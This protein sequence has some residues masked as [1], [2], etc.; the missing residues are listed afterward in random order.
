MT[1]MQA[2][3][4]LWRGCRQTWVWLFLLVSPFCLGQTLDLGDWLRPHAEIL[5][6]WQ[7]NPEPST[8]LRASITAIKAPGSKPAKRVLVLYPRASSA[9]D[10]ALNRLLDVF[11]ERE[12]N[13]T[14]TVIN[15][16]NNPLL[17]IQALEFAKAANMDLIYT[18]GSESTDFVFARYKDGKIPTVSICSKDPVLLGQM[19]D[20]EKGSE[21]H[22]AFTSLNMQI[23]AQLAYLQELKPKLRN[24]GILVDAKNKSAVQ[25]Q[26]DPIAKAAKAI[27]IEPISIVVKEPEMAVQEL[28]Q[29]I[30]LALEAMR[31]TDPTLTN[32]V[33]WLTGSTSVFKE[34]ATINSVSANVPVISVVP[35]VA[36]EGNDSAVLSIGISFDSNAYLAAI[37]GVDILTGKSRPGELKVGIVSPPDIAI[38]FRRARQIGLKIPFSFFERAGYIYDYDGKPARLKGISQVVTK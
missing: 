28:L 24:I 3:V 22:F 8:P 18:M 34:I 17:G 9:Y 15:F 12:M 2:R 27:G 20:Y 35:E 36:T 5:K 21:T 37:Y 13:A 11:H 33:F 29:K 4:R 10:V 1:S 30:P 14:F 16:Q 7:I 25:T 32:S 6:V 26:A 31:K 38:N 23:D 19:K